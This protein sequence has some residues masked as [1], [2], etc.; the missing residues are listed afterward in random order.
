MSPARE[1]TAEYGTG[2]IEPDTDP[3]PDPDG[4]RGHVSIFNNLIASEDGF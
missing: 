4:K 2:R 1:E 3:D